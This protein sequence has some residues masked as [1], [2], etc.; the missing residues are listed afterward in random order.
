[1]A[2]MRRILVLLL[3]CLVLGA[4]AVA[5]AA[6]GAV[7]KAKDNFFKPKRVVISVG[8]KV[9]WVN[10]GN[11]D[12]TTS[13]DGWNERLNPDEVF[14]RRFNAMGTFRYKC[15]IHDDMRGKV[16]VQ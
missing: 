2:L 15:R 7:V 8:E 9:K 6:V 3:V 1:M 12:H 4:P 10:R 14:R 13:G 16:I 11:N 5:N